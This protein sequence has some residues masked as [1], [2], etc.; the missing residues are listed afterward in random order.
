MNNYELLNQYGYNLNN[1]TLEIFKNNEY[2]DTGFYF[3]EINRKSQKRIQ[4]R[5]KNDDKLYF[6]ALLKN[7]LET[8][9]IEFVKSWYYATKK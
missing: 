9:A 1:N 7:G 5:C 2:I 8:S 6:S 3:K 4:V